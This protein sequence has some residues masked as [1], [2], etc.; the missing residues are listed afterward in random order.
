MQKGNNANAMKQRNKQRLLELIR[1]SS[2]SRAE[3]ARETGLTRAAISV[4]VDGMI[5]E[6]LLLDGELVDGG[7]GRRTI[8]LKLNGEKYTILSV[9]IARDVCSVGVADF[10]G[11]ISRI[12]RKETGRLGASLE[13]A[14][15]RIGDMADELLRT[16]P[17]K[18]L[19]GIG[20]SAPGPLDSEKGVLLTPARFEMWHHASIV[21]WFEQRY[22]CPVYLENIAKSLALAEKY[23]GIG[24]SYRN[25]MEVLVDTGVGSGIL[26]DG[27][28]YRGITGFAGEVGHM[29]IEYSG[30]SCSCGNRGCL[31]LYASVPALLAYGKEQGIFCPSWKFI[32]DRVKTDKDAG[33]LYE[34]ELDLLA[35]TLTNVMNLLDLEAVILSGDI[36]Y[37]GRQMAAELEKRIN[38]QFIGREGRYIAVQPSGLLEN[39]QTLAGVN[40]VLEHFNREME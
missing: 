22:Q 2:R 15:E 14:L 37:Q 26:L 8:G 36:L 18:N 7:K 3:L 30:K 6:G 33:M 25:Y 4:L 40:L 27:Q 39:A 17:Q 38:K 9:N 10:A 20:I 35:G 34:R 31:E 24:S 23:Y 5:E 29:S 19:L 21:Q 12:L 32:V 13:E 1:I 16:A 28:L 11:N